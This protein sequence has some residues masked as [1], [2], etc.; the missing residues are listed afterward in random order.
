LP[1]YRTRQCGAVHVL[2]DVLAAAGL[3]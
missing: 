2:G 1:G 3:A